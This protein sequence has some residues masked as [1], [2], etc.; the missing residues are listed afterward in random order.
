MRGKIVTGVITAVVLMAVCFG[1]TS[2]KITPEQTKVIAQN[3]GM[4]AAVGWIAYDNP[5]EAAIESVKSILDTIRE[6]AID[7]EAGKTYTEVIYPELVKVID[8]K[9]AE[10]D[11]PLCKAA[12]LTLLNGLDTLFA[13]YPEWK[14]SQDIAI[15]VVEAFVL[16]A[17]NGLSLGEDHEVIKQARDSA[18]RRARIF[19]E[20]KKKRWFRQ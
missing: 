20:P 7:V 8:E 2:C 12:S 19:K 10:K 9:V 15:G 16:G 1:M 18:S 4:F 3:A 11:R 14:E 5:D 13:M 17:K 6:K